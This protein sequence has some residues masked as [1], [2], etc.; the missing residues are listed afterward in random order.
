M[1]TTVYSVYKT[2]S[3]TSIYL[4]SPILPSVLLEC[5]CQGTGIYPQD[6]ATDLKGYE[7]WECT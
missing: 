2:D 4:L 3:M 6:I 7:L 5:T 1:K